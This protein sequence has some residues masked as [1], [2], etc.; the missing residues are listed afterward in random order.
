M[1]EKIQHWIQGCFACSLCSLWG[2]YCIF[3]VWMIRL[4]PCTSAFCSLCWKEENGELVLLRDTNL[5]TS[6]TI[7]KAR[8]GF[9]LQWYHNTKSSFLWTRA[10][11]DILSKPYLN[12]ASYISCC[13]APLL[14][15]TPHSRNRY[16]KL[17]ISCLPKKKRKK[18]KFKFYIFFLKAHILTHFSVFLC[19]G[20]VSFEASGT[21]SLQS[22][23]GLDVTKQGFPALWHGSESVSV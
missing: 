6:R 17:V 14:V 9:L 2:F 5:G 1:G 12:P 10:Y 8:T 18:K 4:L 13:Q 21:W 20:F 15:H 3:H 11:P 22:N 23:E 16:C 19:F 7:W